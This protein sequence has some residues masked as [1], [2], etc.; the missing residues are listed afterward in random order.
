VLGRLVQ[1][2][3]LVR[4]ALKQGNIRPHMMERAWIMIEM[5]LLASRYLVLFTESVSQ[6][7]F[8]TEPM[9]ADQHDADKVIKLEPLKKQFV[10]D[11]IAGNVDRKTHPT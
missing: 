10:E 6:A 8:Y 4:T 2:G 9:S 11:Y 5:G 1:N 3:R 7:S